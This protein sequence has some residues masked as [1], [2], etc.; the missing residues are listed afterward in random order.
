VEK[1]KTLFR[2]DNAAPVTAALH[3][4]A[5]AKVQ[6]GQAGAAA[7]RGYDDIVHKAADGV[8]GREGARA[9]PD[10]VAS[11]NGVAG[12]GDDALG[13]ADGD[14]QKRLKA[15][16]ERAARQRELERQRFLLS[17]DP[18]TW[19]PLAE[20][21]YFQKAEDDFK[22][23]AAEEKAVRGISD[24]CCLLLHA[25]G[26]TPTHSHSLTPSHT[27]SRTP[28]HSHPPTPPTTLSLALSRSLSILLSLVELVQGALACSGCD[29]HPPTR[30]HAHART[31]GRTYTHTRS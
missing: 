28:T 25:L 10:A 4:P 9:E 31:H 30:T 7:R 29:A 2:P 22:A 8:M 20:E 16:E 1:Y 26:A 15:M 14:R 5:G 18:A 13:A 19:E 3:K 24:R 27:H 11:G 21:G 6:D 12:A 17:L 23:A